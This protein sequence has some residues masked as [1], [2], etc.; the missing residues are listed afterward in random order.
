MYF[1]GLGLILLALKSLGLGAV[2]NWPWWLVLLPFVLAV[3]WW[4]WADWSGHTKKKTMERENR[5]RDER[6]ERNRVAMGTP[7]KGGKR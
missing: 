5:R 4:T 2:A 1:L 3:L 7:K 6:I